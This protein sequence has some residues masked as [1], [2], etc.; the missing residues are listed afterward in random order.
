MAVLPFNA[1]SLE[2]FL[3]SRELAEFYA[4]NGEPDMA[5]GAIEKG[6]RYLARLGVAP[7][8]ELDNEILERAYWA[9]Y[10]QKLQ[11]AREHLAHNDAG[12]AKQYLEEAA[13]LSSKM[14]YPSSLQGR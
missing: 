10:R 9:A 3:T 6:R 7:S 12:M 5:Q 14:R 13:A 11:A 2:T 8:P 1:A 4:D